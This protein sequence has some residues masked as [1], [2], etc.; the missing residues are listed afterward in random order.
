MQFLY[1]PKLTYEFL[2]FSSTSAKSGVNIVEWSMLNANVLDFQYICDQQHYVIRTLQY[3]QRT[4]QLGEGDVNLDRV[5]PFLQGNAGS[6]WIDICAPLIATHLTVAAGILLNAS[7]P[8][9][10]HW[11]AA[12]MYLLL[13]KNSHCKRGVCPN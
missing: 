7:E 8:G 3:S 1:K 10:C 11:L 2:L 13:C 9:K 4:V 5:K 6:K 12:A